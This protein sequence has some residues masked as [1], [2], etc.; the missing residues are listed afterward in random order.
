MPGL[1][2]RGELTCSG[3]HEHRLKRVRVMNRRKEQ[4]LSVTDLQEEAL[5]LLVV[6]DTPPQAG[7][8]RD[9]LL[10]E[11]PSLSISVATD[12]ET[13]ESAL[14]HARCDACLLA[15][16]LHWSNVSAIIAEIR[17]R[18]PHCP[19]LM[20]GEDA[21]ASVRREAFAA[22]LTD[23]ISGKSGAEERL[24]GA[25]RLASAQVKALR[26]TA[27]AER[28]LLDAVESMR[29]AFVIYDKNDR[30]FMCNSRYREF[31]PQSA[32]AVVPGAR[33]EDILHAGLQAGEIV[34]AIGREQ[35]WLA[36]R[37]EAH[38]RPVNEM[39]QHLADD[40][41]LMVKEY[42]S[43]D[44]RSVGIRADITEFKHREAELAAL[45]DENA[46]LAAVARSSATGVVVSDAHAPDQPIIFVNP[47]FTEITGYSLAECVGRNSRFL[48]GPDTDPATVVAIGDAVRAG[49]PVEA[50]ILNYRKDG[51]S[52]WNQ[53][54]IDPVFDGNG[55]LTYFVGVQSD[56]SESVDTRRTLSE[57][58]RMLSDAE[59]IA[60]V[61]HWR[62]HIPTDDMWWSDE[63]YRIR[64]LDP[65]NISPYFNY[66]VSTYHPDDQERVAAAVRK[67]GES[68]EPL[69]FE[70]RIVRADGEVR[71]VYVT[72]R[73]VPEQDGQ[74]ECIFGILQDITDFKRVQEAVEARERQYREL[75]A[76]IPHGIVSLD[77]ESTIEV[78]NPAHNQM[79]SR[80]SAPL[81]GIRW[82]NLIEGEDERARVAALFEKLK[83]GTPV[84][85]F[86]TRYR[87]A[88]GGSLSVQVD[89]AVRHD[90]DGSVDG[91]TAI[92]TDITEQLRADERLRYLAYYDPLT[93]LPNRRLYLDAL[94]DL[95][96]GDAGP[97]AV[98]LI[99]I[100]GFKLFNDTLGQATGD[101]VLK[102][103]AQRLSANIPPMSRAARF[104]ADEFALLLPAEHDQGR[105]LNILARIKAE[106]EAP[107]EIDGSRIDLTLSFGVSRCPED[108]QEAGLVLGNADHALVGAKR[109]EPGAIRFYTEAMRAA[110]EEFVL[111][112]G[113]LRDALAH[114][115]FFLEYQPQVDIAS[116]RITALE[117]L[118]R[119]RT[120]D[121][122]L[123]PPGKFIPIAERGGEIVPLGRWVLAEA[124][125]QIAEWASKGIAL[126][127][128]AVNMSARQFLQEDLVHTVRTALDQADVAPHWLK[129][130]ITETALMADSMGSLNRMRELKDLGIH[131]ALDDFGTGYS[132]LSY[133]S[134][135]PIDVLKIDRSFIISMAE[136][137]QAA[138]VNAVIAMGKRLGID[139]VAEGVDAT[140]QLE[141]LREW[142]CE[143]VQGYFFSRPVSADRCE[144]LLRAGKPLQG[145]DDN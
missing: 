27:E 37:M 48:Q 85:P 36:E 98:V 72:G 24:L 23:S 35:E 134:R 13:L 50:E 19:V 29:D 17:G 57:Q 114:N 25:I 136:P 132:S 22:G 99:N 96:A 67:A 76:A 111:L 108:G 10:P 14:D 135:F 62:W 41:W 63:I 127:P 8:L 51:Q 93:G 144:A 71:H 130:E 129:I 53:M 40:R 131:F 87:R 124:A 54:R 125:R 28:T 90:S 133:L 42:R 43:P 68:R 143:S 91:I 18:A 137:K 47:A 138:I 64:G 79:L 31:Y 107:L 77:C 5:R 119:W 7:A 113:R 145:A 59:R 95:L 122:T 97:L 12:P 34:N 106:L 142:G 101:A 26:A 20:Y 15:D 60:H 83:Q 69:D 89:I 110:T 102:S 46:M 140:A 141:R 45:A 2:E 38:R 105:L 65:E 21:S 52:F 120:V 86:R 126:V 88:D 16:V 3:I 81:T 109:E 103:V 11:F 9:I 73:Y 61:G 1:S 58:A 74:T 116:G 94:E 112:R 104:S 49:R 55:D 84:K 92:V 117:A 123:I 75:V 70:A 39:E 56:I 82:L 128:V 78:S 121:G 4:S 115:E 6:A 44:G 33:F 139:V 80:A 30:L 32:A 118:V 66:T 100:D